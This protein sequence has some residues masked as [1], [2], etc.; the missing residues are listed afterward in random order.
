MSV[1]FPFGTSWNFRVPIL[2]LCALGIGCSLANSDPP[3]DSPFSRFDLRAGSDLSGLADLA[4][5]TKDLSFDQGTI[6]STS[7]LVINEV[8]PNGSDAT[9]DPDFIELYNRGSGQINLRGYKVRDHNATWATLPDDA[10]IP[11][12][13]YFVINCDGLSSGLP[14]P[15]VPFK[16]G[17]SGDEVHIA[18]PDG[19]EIDSA[20]WGQATIDIPKGQSLGR[21]PDQTGSFAVLSKP[22][23]GKPNL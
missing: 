8:F 15:H 23:R 11:A 6:T 4:K 14:G 22:S 18:S 12:G 5:E 19:F 1:R 2:A 21:N 10:V 9:T 17:G 20:V 13:A 3:P 7:P 16:L